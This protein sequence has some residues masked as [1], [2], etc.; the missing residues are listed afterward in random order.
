MKKIKKLMF[1]LVCIMLVGVMAGIMVACDGDKDG[2]KPSGATEINIMN[3]WKG[4]EN[5]ETYKVNDKTAG[6]L[7]ISYEKSGEWQFVGRSFAYES[8]AQ[9]KDVKTLVFE[10]QMESDN[11]VYHVL[12][13]I[14]GYRDGSPNIEVPFE[15]SKDKKTYEWDMTKANLPNAGTLYLF[16]EP[17]ATSG[18]GKITFTKFALTTAPINQ[19]NNIVKPVPAESE[20]LNEIT[21]DSLTFNK[22]WVNNDNISYY[23][24]TKDGANFKVD[25]AK[26]G[27]AYT[28]MYALVKGSAIEDMKTIRLTVQGTANDVLMIKPYD[29]AEKSFTLTGEDDEIVVD[30][31][32]ITGV[33]YTTAQKILI[34]AAPGSK[35]ATGTFTI[36]NATFS[37][38]PAPVETQTIDAS[39]KFNSWLSSGDGI[40]T[41]S[42]EEVGGASVTKVVYNKGAG[43]EWNSFKAKVNGAHLKEMGYLEIAFS[44]GKAGAQ[45]LVKPFNNN[46]LETR[47]TFDEDGNASARVNVSAYTSAITDVEA[48]QEIH[49]MAEAGSANVSGEFYITSA[50]FTRNVQYITADNKAI[51]ANAYYNGDAGI[52]SFDYT[53]DG[54]VVTKVADGSWAQV[55]VDVNIAS[56]ANVST[57]TLKLANM[58]GKFFIAGISEGDVQL[59]DQQKAEPSETDTLEF[60]FDISAVPKDTTVN[61][62]MY[63]QWDEK[64]EETTFTITEAVFA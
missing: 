17:L 41:V 26:K 19:A 46:T 16:V 39:G 45:I 9:L 44:G 58:Q 10:A 14:E 25:Y 20:I 54:V 47:V 33:D 56:D 12:L 8:E 22:A 36:K 37:T 18:S 64:L 21:A 13:K 63:F 6:K 35:T 31:S 30:V 57:F 29:K 4:N 11:D 34:L 28:S 24:I 43:T 1:L 52:Y 61:L 51:G 42:Q 59:V 55:R 23:N 38:E 49:L 5:E 60:T 2:D 62:V 15:L 50:Q 3:Y 40:Y 32:T 48:V 7:E 53:A 27:N